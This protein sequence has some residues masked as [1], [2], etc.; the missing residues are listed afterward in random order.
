MTSRSPR[1]AIV[2]G[3]SRGIGFEI[4]RTLIANDCRVVATSRYITSA[5]TLMPTDRVK[6]VNGDVGS[7]SGAEEVVGVGVR[8]FGRVDLLVNT[9]GRFI[10]K[11]FTGVGND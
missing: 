3:A 4:A 11:P 8:E 10:P 5:K 2:T 7:R 1:V 9:A 6:L